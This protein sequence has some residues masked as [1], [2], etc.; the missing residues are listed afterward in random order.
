MHAPTWGVH[1]FAACFTIPCDLPQAN[2]RTSVGPQ[3]PP[4]ASV[5]RHLP[6]WHFVAFFQSSRIKQIELS[7]VCDHTLESRDHKTGKSSSFP[8]APSKK[9][10]KI[11]H[12]TAL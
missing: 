1:F 3:G 8:R 12:M 2:L 5:A 9:P 6:I 10:L 7:N 11:C 4:P